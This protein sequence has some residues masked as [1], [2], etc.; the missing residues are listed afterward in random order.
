MLHQLVFFLHMAQNPL[1]C[2]SAFEEGR[3]SQDADVSPISVLGF[4]ANPTLFQCGDEKE[5]AKFAARML[6]CTGKVMK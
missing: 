6:S 5:L 1:E 4:W 2:F 3:G